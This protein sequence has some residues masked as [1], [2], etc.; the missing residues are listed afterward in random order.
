MPRSGRNERGFT[1]CLPMG[2]LNRIRI[3]LWM[4]R[5]EFYLCDTQLTDSTKV[6]GWRVAIWTPILSISLH[7]KAPQLLFMDVLKT[8]ALV[9]WGPRKWWGVTDG[10]LAFKYEREKIWGRWSVYERCDVQIDGM[11]KFSRYLV[12][13]PLPAI[14]PTKPDSI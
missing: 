13:M 10:E 6:R 7:R 11:P 8:S 9:Y 2:L 4:W 3:F 14:Q 5:F 1:L 12:P